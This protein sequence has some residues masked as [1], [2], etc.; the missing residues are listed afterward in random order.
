MVKSVLSKAG[1]REH[2]DFLLHLVTN[3]T[4]MDNTIFIV[5]NRSIVPL[6][7]RVSLLS[8][9]T[10]ILEA[11]FYFIY[12]KKWCYMKSFFFL[13]SFNKSNKWIPILFSSFEITRCILNHLWFLAVKEMS[14]H[15]MSTKTSSWLKN[16]KNFRYKL[17]R[18]FMSGFI[19]ETFQ[20]VISV[21]F[22]NAI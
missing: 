8:H 2:L 12:L 18:L 6:A 4:L 13:L 22:L 10:F 11:F 5:P 15:V 1:A 20:F 7:V 3:H 19:L 17:L 21:R 9:F 16:F 14:C